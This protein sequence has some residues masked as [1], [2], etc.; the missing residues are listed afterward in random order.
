VALIYMFGIKKQEVNLSFFINQF[1]LLISLFEVGRVYF[2]IILMKKA[3]FLYILLSLACT[4]IMSQTQYLP[5]EAKRGNRWLVGYDSDTIFSNSEILNFHFNNM[6][7]VNWNLENRNINFGGTSASICDTNGNLI[8]YTNGYKLHDGND[9]IIEDSLSYDSSVYANYYFEGTPI[10]NGALILP[11]PN[12]N[13][14]YIVLHENVTSDAWLLNRFYYSIADL[15]THSLTEKDHLLTNDTLATGLTAVRHGNGRDWWIIVPEYGSNCYY[16]F[17]ISPDTILMAGKQCLGRR[18]DENNGA[19]QA[20][21]SPKGDKYIWCNNGNEANI[22]DFDR[23]NGILSN[24]LHLQIRTDTN[25]IFAPVRAHGVAVSPNNRFLYVGAEE[26]VLQFDL[27]AANIAASRTTVAVWDSFYA[28]LPT[29]FANANTAIDGRIYIGTSSSQ[30][31]HVIDKPNLQGIACDV[32]QHS[33]LL[34]S[35]YGGSLPNTIFYGLGR[36]IG[37]A[38]DTIFTSVSPPQAGAS[39]QVYPN[40]AK[41]QLTVELS[42]FRQ[43][44]FCTF[45]NLVGQKVH[46]ETLLQATTQ[47]SVENWEKGAY[48]YEIVNGKKRSY[49]K[50]FIE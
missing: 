12:S 9:N 5:S 46:S 38:C 45:Y 4:S 26:E 14:Q 17:S 19:I 8:L 22:Y 36:E 16:V 44:L 39:V 24:S 20:T 1:P 21:F 3:F 33:L 48:F 34:P 10:E 2:I 6:G 29:V 31:M 32:Q 49:G 23:C 27:S 28:P 42:H 35:Y 25:L 13:N 30:Y 43:P 11:K 15:N 47:I 18:R 40:P 7:G 41:E 37:S 50:V